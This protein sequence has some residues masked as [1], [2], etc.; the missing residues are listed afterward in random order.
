MDA[1]LRQSGLRRIG[2]AGTFFWHVD[3][4]VRGSP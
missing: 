2:R 3:V 1:S 4:Y